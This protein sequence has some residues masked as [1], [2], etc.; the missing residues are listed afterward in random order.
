MATKRLLGS[1]LKKNYG[2]RTVL[3]GVTVS[4][5]AGEVVGLLGPNGAGKTTSFRI[6][7][8]LIRPDGGTVT[9]EGRDLTGEPLYRRARAG[10]AYLPQETSIFRGMTVGENLM[11]ILEA[12][13]GPVRERR[14]R[15]TGL[16]REFGVERLE[17]STASTLS[18]GE[19]RRVEVARALIPKPS[20]LMLDEPFSGIDPIAV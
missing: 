19:K 16:L 13:G 11:A 10:I 6:I 1:D 12:Q 2:K 7:A 14:E 17:N 20:F 5:D 4:V 3:R 18:G 9:L 8:G 15:L